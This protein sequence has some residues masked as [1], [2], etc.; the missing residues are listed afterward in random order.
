[1]VDTANGPIYG[2]TEMNCGGVGGEPTFVE[3]AKEEGET[4]KFG[5]GRK[6]ELVNAATV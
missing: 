2:D 6:A 3:K 1:V 5:G 4:V